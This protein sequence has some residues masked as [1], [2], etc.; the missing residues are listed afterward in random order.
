MSR[1]W[2]PE[3]PLKDPDKVTEAAFIPA[4][5]E[6]GLSTALLGIHRA[7]AGAIAHRCAQG[8]MDAAGLVTAM[9]G[10]REKVAGSAVT[11]IGRDYGVRYSAL[12]V[13]D[14]CDQAEQSAHD[15]YT[16]MTA[17]GI[18]PT[19][20]ASRTAAV[21]G[22]PLRSMGKY[23]AAAMDPKSTLAVLNDAADR[24]LMDHISHVVRAEKASAKAREAKADIAKAR[25]FRESDVKRDEL[26]QFAE[27][28]AGRGVKTALQSK[29]RSLLAD[30]DVTP[31]GLREATE[32]TPTK[33][34]PVDPERE[35]KKARLAERERKKAHLAEREKKKAHL[36]RREKQKQ[37]VQ[38]A[39]R[40]APSDRSEQ[41]RATP[42][43]AQQAR[44]TQARA[45]AAVALQQQV[46]ARL[47]EEKPVS[48]VQKKP[49]N[50]FELASGTNDL[51][52]HVGRNDRTYGTIADNVVMHFTGSEWEALRSE[53]FRRN[54]QDG[55][56]MVGRLGNMTDV[57]NSAML[58]DRHDE[59]YHSAAQTAQY[60]SESVQ[61][62]SHTSKNVEV[63]DYKVEMD[64]NST[65]EEIAAA[66]RQQVRDVAARH[67]TN[68]DD[69]VMAEA[70]PTYNPYGTAA[71]DADTSMHV[72][73]HQ[74]INGRKD[75]YRRPPEVVEMIVHDAS[76]EVA[77]S[78]RYG[79]VEMDPDQAYRVRS[80]DVDHSGPTREKVMW[81][82]KNQTL[83][84]RLHLFPVDE[85]EIEGFAKARQFRESDVKRDELG[86]FAEQNT[87]GVKLAGI[88]ERM[89]YSVAPP[90]T[91]DPEQEQ[92]RARLAER[93]QKK[94]RLAERG[95]KK[96]HLQ[97]RAARATPAQPKDHA[98]GQL[99][100]TARR[101]TAQ[102]ATARPRRAHQAEAARRLALTRTAGGALPDVELD[103]AN[104]YHAMSKEDFATMLESVSD[105]DIDAMHAP[106]GR[107][108]HLDGTARQRLFDRTESADDVIFTMRTNVDDDLNSKEVVENDKH[109]V[110]PGH[111]GVDVNMIEPYLEKIFEQYPDT[112]VV[113]I[114]RNDDDQIELSWST[115]PT[116]QQ[117]LV[118][119]PDSIDPDKTY[120][121]TYVGTYKLRNFYG[122]SHDG[123]R[124]IGGMMDQTQLGGGYALNP[125]ISYYRVSAPTVERYRAQEQ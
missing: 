109:Q 47:A 101:A 45:E 97:R 115:T 53:M 36:D 6:H 70:F 125:S 19:T 51:L 74:W 18:P 87:S 120:T 102:Q 81:D 3:K 39:R 59:I 99:V 42:A 56:G 55:R 29:V 69:A 86:Q 93:E 17:R 41:R 76:G 82:P 5:D 48:N 106:G 123:I 95:K 113:D 37:A 27:Q 104:S 57:P 20:A 73:V 80:S 110:L 96:A 100:P 63:S 50:V 13:R 21:Y 68:P 23:R 121:L 4:E 105:E 43:R 91:T 85:D 84:R 78:G 32:P 72:V 33:A 52:K 118:D 114:V 117:V 98:R 44:A 9:A 2:A 122:R 26:G 61:L 46:S 12:L 31:R 28:A 16:A 64:L 116:E 11:A 119:V 107:G 111:V 7:V 103:E 62:Q 35:K 71:E 79:Q 34:E 15:L 67:S 66:V 38:R 92:K 77:G 54:Q 124:S 112:G 1:W 49:T 83:V 58:A 89:G 90:T 22:V 14:W 94:A 88:A 10:M 25:Q 60:D 65:A 75:G 24:A 40:Q 108:V 30:V 8:P